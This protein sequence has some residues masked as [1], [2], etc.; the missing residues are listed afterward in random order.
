M[1]GTDVDRYIG[2]RIRRVRA[3]RALSL[4]EL[5]QK[6]LRILEIRGVPK[7]SVE[8]KGYNIVSLSETERGL[9]VAKPSK[10]ETIAAALEIEVSKLQ[11][12]DWMKTDDNPE[13]RTK[14]PRNCKDLVSHNRATI[15]L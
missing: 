15:V 14:V 8:W 10:L 1:R 12:A 3:Y 4:A 5:Q 6:C 13:R 7:D 2:A 9:T 11:P